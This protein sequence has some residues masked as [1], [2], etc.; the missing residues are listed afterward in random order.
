MNQ[1]MFSLHPN[2][3]PNFDEQSWIN[4][5]RRAFDQEDDLEE[6]SDMPVS[7]FNVPKSLMLSSSD[8]YIPQ[9]VAIGPYHHFRP[10]LYE[11]E[12][13]KIYAA[14]RSKRQL[15]ALRFQHLLYHLIKL[16]PMFRACYQNYLNFNGET[17]AWM[18]LVDSCFLLEF[19]QA[20]ALKGDRI[21]TRASSRASPPGRQSAN[22]DYAIVRDMI[23][24]EN[25]IPLFCLRKVLEFQL[26]SL[27]IEADNKLHALLIGFC[28]ELSPFKNMIQELPDSHQ[29]MNC[30]HLLDLLYH[31]IV[32]KYEEITSAEIMLEIEEQQTEEC[33][34]KDLW[35][36]ISKFKTGLVRLIK[37]VLVSK[38]AHLVFKIPWKII[39]NL[40]GFII[41]RQLEY[42]CSSRDKERN[43][44]E[45]IISN[46]TNM[47]PTIEEITI[48]SVTELSKAGV[49]FSATDE[50]ISSIRF[51]VE[52]ATFHLPTIVLDVNTEVAIRNLIA[53][54][55]CTA[56]G[57]SVLTRYAELVNGII[58]TE[59]DAKVLR[60]KGI[61]LNHLKSDEDVASLCNGMTKS[62]QL[63]KVPFL[64]KVIE[65]LNVCYNQSLRVKIGK[66]MAQNV[67]GSWQSLALMAAVMV[68]SLMSFQAF[69]SAFRCAQMFRR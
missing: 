40:P 37:R 14:K 57:P 66:F 39:S 43:G 49:K 9:R 13:N 58:D 56:T 45:N 41:L 10:E 36:T 8:S 69:C 12:R 18:M 29:V 63:T 15:Q 32:P 20:Y 26:G 50:G 35:K 61:I 68:L 52:S 60:E 62:V 21:L 24:L 17:L 67:Y 22:H 59:E 30:V 38:P 3:N 54:E 27:T 19:L 7:I 34:K 25:Q 2:S 47:P 33:G 48:P 28:K 6:E 1:N 51:D 65:D 44:V 23:M 42:I 31:L 46:N 16:E 5:I 4:Q 64:D 55:S 11:M 53:Y